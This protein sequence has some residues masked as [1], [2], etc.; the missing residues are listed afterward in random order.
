MIILP[1]WFLTV[2]P[3]DQDSFGFQPILR[4]TGSSPSVH[5]LML[6][7]QKSAHFCIQLL[8]KNTKQHYIEFLQTNYIIWGK[9]TK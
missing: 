9:S 1:D 3:A 2:F 4:S 8:P 6:N 7:K 5:F